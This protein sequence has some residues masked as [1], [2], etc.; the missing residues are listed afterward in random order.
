[1]YPLVARNGITI[2]NND[3][4]P[5]YI[6]DVLEESNVVTDVLTVPAAGFVHCLNP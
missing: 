4:L 6:L 2:P 1:M 3:I 5:G